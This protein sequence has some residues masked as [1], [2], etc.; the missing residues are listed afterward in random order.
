ML[1]ELEEFLSISCLCSCVA[2]EVSFDRTWLN[3]QEMKKKKK[4]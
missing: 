1:M 2:L 4:K 3:L